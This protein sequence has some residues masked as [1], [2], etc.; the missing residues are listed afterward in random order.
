MRRKTLCLLLAAVIGFSAA[1]CDPSGS[2]REPSAVPE[3]AV[4][5]S[6]TDTPAPTG[7]AVPEGEEK[8]A[9]ETVRVTVG[10]ETESRTFADDSGTVTLLDYAADRP[11]VEIRGRSGAAEAINRVLEEDLRRFREGEESADYVTGQEAFLSAAREDLSWRR[12]D[13]NGDSFVPYM[14]QRRAGVPR[15]DDRVLSVVFDETTFLGGVHP[16]TGRSAR[17]FDTRTGAELKLEDLAED[18]AAFLDRCAD[19]LWEESRGGENTLMAMAGYYDGYEDTLPELLRDGNWYFNEAGLVV[20]ANPYEIAPYAA[21]RI[22]CTLPYDWLRW[23]IKEEYL[24]PEQPAEGRITGEILPQ[25]GKADVMLD[26]GTQGQGAC[27]FLTAEGDVRD[28]RLTRVSYN[29]WNNT[30]TEN[31]TFWV[32]SGLAAGETLLLRTWIG[33]VIPTLKLSCVSAGQKREVYISQ[34]GKDGSLVLLDGTQF[35]SLPLEITDRLPFSR[36]VDGDSVPEVID[37]T[38][39]GEEDYRRL[40]VDGEPLSDVFSADP[41]RMHL[42]LTDLDADGKAELLYC[43]DMGS[44]DYVTSAWHADTLEPIRFTME[45]RNGRDGRERTDTADGKVVFSMERL[46]LESW[47]YQLGTY[48]SV[49]PYELL[50]GSVIAPENTEYLWGSGDWEYLTNRVYLTVK[51]DLPVTMDGAGDG[52]L[53]PGT[54]ILLLGTDGTTVRFRTEDGLTGTMALELHDGDDSGWYIGGVRETDCFEMLPYA[55]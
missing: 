19:R 9:S 11:R 31:G 33:D 23:Q 4:P 38:D 53:L 55:G 25:P 37:L 24:P 15:G 27:V 13:G 28:V 16:Y 5:E 10:V 3:T 36:D 30:F 18:P 29:N 8:T 44:D 12:K 48:A 14:L 50:D 2:G 1:A 35:L 47:T 39:A 21:G 34:S 7:T 26:D 54:R 41:E 45:T 52:T 42:W 46:F 43:A 22:E 40:T 32:A 51:R 20:I 6:R 49:R 17:N